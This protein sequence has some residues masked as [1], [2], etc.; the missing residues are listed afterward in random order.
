MLRFSRDRV[1]PAAP[2]GRD[3]PDPQGAPGGTDAERGADL[4]ERHAARDATWPGPDGVDAADEVMVAETA[5]GAS[6]LSE[7]RSPAAYRALVGVAQEI[8]SA[9]TDGATPDASRIMTCLR[10]AVERLQESD[11]LLGETVRQRS[12][13]HSW[14]QRAAN[15]AILALRLGIELG[16]AERRL[17]GLGSCA[18]MHDLGMLTLPENLA[19]SRRLTPAQRRLLNDHTLE[20]QR[21]VE[22][23]GDA[24]AWIGGIVAQVHE[25]L[26]GS[27]YPCGLRGDEI[28]E[29]ARIVGLAD[30]YDAMVHPRADRQARVVYNALLE[31]IDLR[32][33]LFDPHLV[34]GLIEIVSIYPL[35]S[36]VKLNNGELGRVVGTNGE[37]PMRPK[38]DILVNSRGRRLPEPRTL[39]LMD[40]PMLYITDPAIEEGALDS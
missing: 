19:E 11:A 31:I 15:A 18:L 8:F 39:D 12:E 27:G 14:P 25:R 2:H 33:T 30:T 17:L 3:E 7:D 21:L 23:F 1:A 10:Q 4:V 32:R 13:E 38:V 28:H 24:F 29:F 22:Q 35:G 36:L 16:Y 9:A 40:E 26:D 34:K 5:A 6:S 20:S 37:H